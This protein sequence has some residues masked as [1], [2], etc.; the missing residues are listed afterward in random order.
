MSECERERVR[1]DRERDQAET[2]QTRQT[3]MRQTRQKQTRCDH[4][5]RDRRKDKTQV[6]IV[7]ESDT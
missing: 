3:E 4:G 2:R 7:R 6:G 1:P 5:E